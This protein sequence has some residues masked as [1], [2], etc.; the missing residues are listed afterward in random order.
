ML[1]LQM[2]QHRLMID[3]IDKDNQTTRVNQQL[4]ARE[5]IL[6]KMQ[7]QIQIRDNLLGLAQKHFTDHDVDVD[8]DDPKLVSIEEIVKINSSLPPIPSASGNPYS[9]K[10]NMGINRSNVYGSHANKAVPKNRLA[11]S[12]LPPVPMRRDSNDS[13]K[14]QSNKR[15]FFQS[16]PYSNANPYVSSNNRR[17]GSKI[18]TLRGAN[19]KSQANGG[20]SF[21]SQMRRNKHTYSTPSLKPKNRYGYKAYTAKVREP[22]SDSGIG[23]SINS[24][25]YGVPKTGQ[26]KNYAIRNPYRRLRSPEER[27]RSGSIVSNSSIQSTASS[28]SPG[29]LKSKGG[30]VGLQIAGQPLTLRKENQRMNRSPFAR[31]QQHNNLKNYV[32]NRNKNHAQAKAALSLLNKKNKQL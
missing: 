25:A 7:E 1:D 11:G 6:Q 12:S 20:N 10:T 14:Y 21:H 27:K 8:L 28:N 24:K 13:N 18:P 4:K 22:T 17:D 19:R 31:Q 3:N 23:I 29:G 15:S 5:L 9:L 32:Q 16:K 2:R 26:R 30:V